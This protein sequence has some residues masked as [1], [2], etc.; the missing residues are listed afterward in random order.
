LDCDT[1]DRHGVPRCKHC[2]SDT[3]FVRFLEAPTP[4]IW[5]RCLKSKTPACGGEQTIS[6]AND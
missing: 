6:C 2:G 5:F 3:A 4:R 1:H